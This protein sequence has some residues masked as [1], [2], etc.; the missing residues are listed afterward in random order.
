MA[1]IID[2]VSIEVSQGDPRNVLCEAIDKH[3]ASI[4][5]MGSHGYGAIKRVN[6][7]KPQYLGAWA[8]A[9][10]DAAAAPTARRSSVG[11]RRGGGGNSVW[12]E[13]R[14]RWQLRWSE[15]KASEHVLSCLVI[16]GFI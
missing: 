8:T 3:H 13:E 11:Q 15:V 9:Q 2:D 16:F 7:N 1:L 12:A 14:R 6:R 10:N 4:L 5:V